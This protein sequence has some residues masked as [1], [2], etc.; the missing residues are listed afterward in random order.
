MWQ[1]GQTPIPGYKLEKFLGRGNFGEVW[2][3]SSPGGTKCALKFLNLR[4]RQG[5]KELRAI[6]RLKQIRH[7]NLMPFNAM[8]LLDEQQRV[9]PDDH[10]D[11]SHPFMEDTQRQTLVSTPQIPEQDKP[12][13]LVIAMP[14]AEGNLLELL[15]ERRKLGQDI[16][17]E[18]LLVYMMDAARALDYLNSQ[19][20]EYAGEIVAVQHGDVKPENLVLLGGSVLL[21]DFGVAR[22][23]GTGSATRGTSLGG[24]LAYM[25]PECMAG[26]TSVHSDQFSLA[27]SYVE[28]RTGRLPFADDSM[29]Q[30]IEDR[31]KG[32]LDLEELSPAEARVIQRACSANPDKRFGSSVEMIE[33]LRT[34]V[35]GVAPATRNFN[36][37]ALATLVGLCLATGLLF[38]TFYEPSADPIVDSSA[39]PIVD[40]SADPVGEP[41]AMKM[42]EKYFLEAKALLRSPDVSPAQLADATKLYLSALAH[43]F[44]SEVPASRRM[45]IQDD[46][47]REKNYPAVMRRQLGQL[48]A[49]HPES[50]R[51]LVLGDDGRSLVDPGDAPPHPSI[52]WDQ[53]EPIASIH[54]LDQS[55]L[56]I[57]DLAT[58]LWRLNLETRQAEKIATGVLRVVSSPLSGTALTASSSD[59]TGKSSLMRVRTSTEH[60]IRMPESRPEMFIPLL[61]IDLKGQWGTVFEQFEKA[62]TGIVL[63]FDLASEPPSTLVDTGI[64]PYCCTCLRVGDN[65]YAIV[66]GKSPD[67]ASGLAVLRLQANDNSTNVTFPT[68]AAQQNVF[69]GSDRFVRSLATCVLPDESGGLLAAGHDIGVGSSTTELWEIQPNGIVSFQAFVGQE[70]SG[71]EISALAFDAKGQWLVRGTSW[72]EVRL[73]KLS[74]PELDFQ[75]MSDDYQEEVLQVQ[76]VEDKLIAT[77]KDATILIWNFYECQMVYEAHVKANRPFPTPVN[78]RPQ[79]G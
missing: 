12:K 57:T 17:V 63:Q 58:N 43:D 27:I 42:G 20:H 69:E 56:L 60:Q 54:W 3:A 50:L 39:D 22:T 36:W 13:T 14:V 44:P 23:L 26:Q 32:H 40:S 6:Q 46:V 35:L 28:L 34:A 74:T 79:A 33:A 15:Q 1:T 76:I 10:L 48:V 21:C 2:Q 66:G 49:V 75:L 16:P 68:D 52:S 11:S 31:R 78:F 4:E 70:T 5:R 25:A 24:S 53:P 59:D 29:S 37:L 62:G 73:T 67:H 72:G 65:C 71:P 38:W 9:V 45:G 61:G 41:P 18:E 30:I 47:A 19:R 8:W 64:E 7:A 51:V 77:F 55:H